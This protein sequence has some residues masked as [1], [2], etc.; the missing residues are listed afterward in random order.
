M[1]LSEIAF[2]GIYKWKQFTTNLG[3]FSLCCCNYCFVSAI[4]ETFDFQ[5]NLWTEKL[6]MIIIWYIKY[7]SRQLAVKSHFITRVRYQKFLF[8]FLWVSLAKL[9]KLTETLVYVW[10]FIALLVFRLILSMLWSFGS[11]D[12]LGS[13]TLFGI[14]AMF[15]QRGWGYVNLSDP[16]KIISIHAYAWIY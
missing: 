13:R 14:C 5:V 6:K 7:P 3:V 9:T 12:L 15:M 4:R 1:K 8:K 16:F 10:S 11:R 2:M